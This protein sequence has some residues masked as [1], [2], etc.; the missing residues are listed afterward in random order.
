[1][2]KSVDSGLVLVT[3][4]NVDQVMKYMEEAETKAKE[5]Q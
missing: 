5:T 1:M 4:E 2:P 3:E